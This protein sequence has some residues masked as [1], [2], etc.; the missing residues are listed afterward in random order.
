L[1]Q[2]LLYGDSIVG[3]DLLIKGW[4]CLMFALASRTAC[5]HQEKIERLIPLFWQQRRRQW[6]AQDDDARETRHGSAGTPTGAACASL[7]GSA[8]RKPY[9]KTANGKQHLIRSGALTGPE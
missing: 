8:G 4:S 5:R 2:V 3:I 9:K 6:T 7:A 1:A